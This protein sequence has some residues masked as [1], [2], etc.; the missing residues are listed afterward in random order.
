MPLEIIYYIES[1]DQANIGPI[2]RAR[3]YNKTDWDIGLIYRQ[4]RTNTKKL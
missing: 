4:Y 2:H 3:A 1:G